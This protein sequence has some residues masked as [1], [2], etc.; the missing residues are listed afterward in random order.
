[1]FCALNNKKTEY[2][3]NLNLLEIAENEFRQVNTQ[4]NNSKKIH[5]VYK[6]EFKKVMKLRTEQMNILCK[7]TQIWYQSPFK[8]R[9]I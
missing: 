6:K 2:L 5:S 4:Y 8:L 1:M 7:L 9:S 3:Q